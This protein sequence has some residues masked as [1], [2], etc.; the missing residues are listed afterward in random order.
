MVPVCDK[1]YDRI[2]AA[3]MTI[4]KITS[5]SKILAIIKNTHIW[6]AKRKAE[7][8]ISIKFF[9]TSIFKVNFYIVLTIAGKNVKITTYKGFKVGYQQIDNFRRIIEYFWSEFR[10][11]FLK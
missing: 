1:T 6:K 5:T 4:A 2:V 11:T 9:A 3:I 8:L 10:G 7:D